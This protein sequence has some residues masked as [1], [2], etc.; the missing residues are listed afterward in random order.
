MATLKPFKAWHSNPEY[1]DKIACVPYDVIHTEEAR[2]LAAGNTFSFLRIIRPEIDLPTGFDVHDSEV[3]ETGKRNLSTLLQSQFMSQDEAESL[4][5]YQLKWQGTVKTGV[6]GCVSVQEYEDNIILKHELTRPDKE[7][8]RTRHIHTQQAHAEPVMMAFN[9]NATIKQLLKNATKLAPMFHLEVEDGVEHL[10]WKLDNP[11]EMVRAFTEVPNFY[12]ADGHH[13]CASAARAAKMNPDNEEAGFFP[14]V[15]FPLDELQIL[16]YNRIVYEAPIYFMDELKKRFTLYQNAS[17]IPKNKSE[18]RL[19][20]DGKWMG[21]DLPE[22]ARNDAASQ[23]DIS[24]LQEF[25]LEPL[26]GITD[27][28]TDKNISFVGGIQ[29]P[30]KLQQIVDDGDAAFAISMYPTSIEEL[31]DVS[32]AG[33]LM[34]PKSTWFE[35]K[36]RSGLLIHTF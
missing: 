24:R 17:P 34:P 8:D 2:K 35:P 18:I 36:L 4:Y 29:S 5:V 9:A 22:S 27:Q 28:R 33:Q 13:R 30:K 21:L 3:Y 16:A 7:D 6:F 12:I 20:I 15:L 10:I 25:I 23:L 26:L 14:V 32:D 1:V 19:Y 31:V 11:N